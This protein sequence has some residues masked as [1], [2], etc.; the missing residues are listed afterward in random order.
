MHHYI[1]T[2]PFYENK[3][4]FAKKKLAWITFHFCD[5]LVTLVVALSQWFRYFPRNNKIQGLNPD[6]EQ[7]MFHLFNVRPPF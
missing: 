6:G 5:N 7:S 1:L 4:L 2:C 3:N